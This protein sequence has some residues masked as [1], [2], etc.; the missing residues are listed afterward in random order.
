LALANSDP[1]ALQTLP[2]NDQE[3]AIAPITF[4]PLAGADGNHEGDN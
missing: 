4:Q 1:E 3:L 2:G